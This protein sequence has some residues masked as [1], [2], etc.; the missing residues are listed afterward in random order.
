MGAG[1]AGGSDSNFDIVTN[2]THLSLRLVS[3]NVGIAVVDPFTLHGSAA[4]NIVAVPF[5][6][7]IPMRVRTLRARER[8][9][10]APALAFMRA[11]QQVVREAAQNLPVPV[12]L[13]FPR[14]QAKQPPGPAI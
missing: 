2:Y 7:I 3:N 6:P 14:M 10:T 1:Q 9:R 5:R 12:R 13:H 11:L 8:P 4:E